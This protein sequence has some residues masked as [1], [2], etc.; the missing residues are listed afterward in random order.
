MPMSPEFAQRLEPML[1]RIAAEFGTP[2]HIYDEAGMLEN[3]RLLNQLFGAL[4]GFREYFAQLAA[5]KGLGIQ[6]RIFCLSAVAFV[7][8]P[9]GIHAEE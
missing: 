1:P 8:I 4:P 7:D 5:F 9:F 6:K 2:F 3:G